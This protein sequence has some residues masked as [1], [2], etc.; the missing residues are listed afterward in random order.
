M[1]P[2]YDE[3]DFDV[4]KL[5]GTVKK[6]FK[7]VIETAVML[8]WKVHITGNQSFTL[9]PPEGAPPNAKKFHFG[10]SSRHPNLNA[11]RKAVVRFA[12]KE[13]VQ[14]ADAM[15]DAPTREVAI[16]LGAM[17]PALGDEGTVV[18]DR[19]NGDDETPTKADQ[20]REKRRAR[21]AEV[22][23]A[24]K[25]AAAKKAPAKKPD[26]SRETPTNEERFVVSQRPMLAKQGKGRGGE[27]HAYHSQTT[28]ER[29]W[30]DGSIDYLCAAPDCTA[31]PDGGPYVSSERLKPSRHYANVHAKGVSP[32]PPVFK[33]EVPNAQTYRPRTTRILAL[34]DVLRRVM[35]A[36]VTDPDTLAREALTWVHEQSKGATEHAEEREV[37]TPEETL[38]RVK[39]LLDDGTYFQTQ[40][41]LRAREEQVAHLTAQVERA[42][43]RATQAIENLRS[44]QELVQG[45]KVEDDDEKEAS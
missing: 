17:L 18:D 28:I 10:V 24:T 29:H 27:Q 22:E 38:R 6:D 26:V 37:L 2:M 36:G 25:K 42:E 23:E 19:D 21:A 16:A 31:G 39:M 7:Q 14:T 11:M 40:Q 30:S 32:L 45:I 20:E 34:A 44:L 12:D 35:E 8:G 41:E 15:L 33:A 9:V 4:K 1:S 5:P 43:R 3:T 13:K